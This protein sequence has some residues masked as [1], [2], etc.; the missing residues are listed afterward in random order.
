MGSSWEEHC[1]HRDQVQGDDDSRGPTRW[2]VRGLRVRTCCTVFHEKG[3][4][5]MW[6]VTPRIL[7]YTMDIKICRES[8]QDLRSSTTRHE[9]LLCRQRGVEVTKEMRTVEQG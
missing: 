8:E 9:D 4:S 6:P 1:N 3:A 5:F 7:M 2:E